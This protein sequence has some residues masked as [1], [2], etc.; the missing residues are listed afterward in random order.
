M[1]FE[2]RCNKLLNSEISEYSHLFMSSECNTADKVVIHMKG[3]FFLFLF[4]TKGQ[5]YKFPFW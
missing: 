3:F 4:L 2:A 1:N 5:N